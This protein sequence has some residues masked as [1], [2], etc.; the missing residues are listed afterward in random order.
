MRSSAYFFLKQQ[1][2]KIGMK[3]DS[4]P[5]AKFA[6]GDLKAKRILYRHTRFESPYNTY[7]NKGLPPGPI[8]VASIKSID[9]VLD[10]ESHNYFYMCVDPEKPGYH[11]FAESIEEHNRNA[12]KY[13]RYL[14]KMGIR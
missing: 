8:S 11:L 6:T 4:D 1:G 9:A 10:S 14:D 12:R 5:T 13:H 2:I 3:L 7:L